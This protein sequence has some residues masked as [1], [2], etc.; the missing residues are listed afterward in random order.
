MRMK[1]T[2]M[3]QILAI[4]FVTIILAFVFSKTLA[5][6]NLVGFDRYES[7]SH[8]GPLKDAE[9]VCIFDLTPE[10]YVSI[11]WINVRSQ[12]SCFCH[13]NP[14][15]TCSVASPV[16]PAGYVSQFW[17]VNRPDDPTVGCH[18]TPDHDELVC[19]AQSNSTPPLSCALI[20]GGRDPIKNNGNPSCQVK[21]LD[22][23]N[24]ATGNSFQTETDYNGGGA[25]PL[26]FIRYYNSAKLTMPPTVFGEQWRHSY[27]RS[28][29]LFDSNSSIQTLTTY[30]SDG[31]GYY[32][33]LNNGVWSPDADVTLTLTELKDTNGVRTGWELND[34]NDNVEV[35]DAEGKLLSITNRAG[36]TQT[37][38]YA[39]TTAEGG[40]DDPATL[41]KVTG[42]FG[43]TLQFTYTNGRL[44]SFSDPAG[45][46]YTY[47]YNANGYLA[48]VTYPDKSSG[49]SVDNPKRVY[50]YEDTN[51]PHALTGITDENNQRFNTWA[52]DTQGRAIMNEH[53]GGADHGEISYN[54]DGTS[55]VTHALGMTETLRFTNVLGVAKVT[56]IEGDPC[57]SCA[58]QNKL[59]SYDTNGFLASRTDWEDNQTT[60]SYNTRG[61]EQQRI[62]A[63]GTP[64]QRKTITQWHPTY[65]VPTQID[66]LDKDNK[67]VKRTTNTYDP[68]GRRLN[69]MIES[70]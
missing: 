66:V 7:N 61:L 3:N 35:Y 68:Q 30:R 59:T 38:D 10:N 15:D 55:T 20:P 46:V 29:R 28:I 52:F 67:P 56:A 31:V 11:A 26:S 54:A 18:S 51:L 50:L 58:G 57:T 12:Y 40:D 6:T 47:A 49:S 1:T 22:P 34:N 62:E 5:A 48:S 17:V 42:P 36:L 41:D 39:L 8:T 60:F 63:L 23:I 27:S 16:C 2:K 37:L 64:Q 69:Q 14:G 13:S 25:F 44:D 45:E 9:A 43:R 65:R 19:N 21:K 4:S 53:A 70:L 32:F 33:T 24:T